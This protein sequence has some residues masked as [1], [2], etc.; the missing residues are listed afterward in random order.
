VSPKS[1]N[2][3]IYKPRKIGDPRALPESGDAVVSHCA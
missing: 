1:G 3:T 2:P